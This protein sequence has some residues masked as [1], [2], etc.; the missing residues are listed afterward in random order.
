MHN[1]E[2]VIG[3]DEIRALSI[4]TS[5]SNQTYKHILLPVWNATYKYKDKTYQYV[6]SG[7]TSSVYGNVPRSPLKITLF[8]LMCLAII[9]III[10]VFKMNQ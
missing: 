5:Y 8:V 10:F 3:G 2:Q 6:V 1:I 9:A 7:E 4:N